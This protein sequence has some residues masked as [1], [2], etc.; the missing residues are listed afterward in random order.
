MWKQLVEL[1]NKVFA[2]GEKRNNT[3]RMLKNCARM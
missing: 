3:M 2:L 1:G